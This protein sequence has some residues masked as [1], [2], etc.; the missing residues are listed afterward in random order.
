MA[1]TDQQ[2]QYQSVQDTQ[3]PPPSPPHV[4]PTHA[5]SVVVQD[6]PDSSS[7]NINPLFVEDLKKILHQTSL[8]AQLCANPILVS[9]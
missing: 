3:M 1:T 7:Q 9:V 4:T 5:N 2:Q 6:V 8:Q